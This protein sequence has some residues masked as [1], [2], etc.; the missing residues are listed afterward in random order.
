MISKERLQDLIKNEKMIYLRYNKQIIG[1]KLNKEWFLDGC[2]LC[3]EVEWLKGAFAKHSLLDLYETEQEITDNEIMT[4]LNL[5]QENKKLKS[6]W[7]NLKLFIEGQK[8][9]NEQIDAVEYSQEDII[10]LEKIQEFEQG[11]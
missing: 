2:Y 8:L 5:K 3:R 10:I 6:R 4:I 9:H 7:Q 11:E 1:L